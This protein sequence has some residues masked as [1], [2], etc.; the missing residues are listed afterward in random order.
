MYDTRSRWRTGSGWFFL[1]PEQNQEKCRKLEKLTANHKAPFKPK[2]G[3]SFNI[4]VAQKTLNSQCFK[5]D[6]EQTHAI[7]TR[8]TYGP[9]RSEMSD[10]PGRDMQMLALRWEHCHHQTGQVLVW[11]WPAM[12]TRWGSRGPRGSSREKREKPFLSGKTVP[13]THS[14]SL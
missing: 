10:L 14:S 5:N 12:G 2:A 4:L 8:N 3:E 13:R 11:R 7:P 1:W 6:K 9:Y